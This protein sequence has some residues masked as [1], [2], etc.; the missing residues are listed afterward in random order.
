MEKHEIVTEKVE[1]AEKNFGIIPYLVGPFNHSIYERGQYNGY[2][3]IPLEY[4]NVLLRKPDEDDWDDWDALYWRWTGPRPHGGVTFGMETHIHKF[5]LDMDGHEFPSSVEDKEFLVV[6]FDTAHL[7][8]TWEDWDFEAV[9][10]ET[11]RW[12]ESVVG[13]IEKEIK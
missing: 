3:A 7:D 13:Y 10:N 4:K 2:L 8:D 11:E 9:A 12:L 6:G 1:E 5:A